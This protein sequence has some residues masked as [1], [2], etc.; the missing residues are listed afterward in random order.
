MAQVL[1]WMRKIRAEQAW[2][3]PFLSIA[4]ASNATRPH[5]SRIK[6]ARRGVA[7]GLPKCRYQFR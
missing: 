3:V 2:N 6:I 5:V 1:F 4:G 7:L